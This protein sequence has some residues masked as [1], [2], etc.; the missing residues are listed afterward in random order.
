MTRIVKLAPALAAALVASQAVAAEKPVTAKVCTNCHQPQEGTLRG[1]FDNVAFKSRSIQIKFDDAVEVV[2]FD[3]KAIEVKA[4]AKTDPAEALREVKKG[5]EIKIAFVVKDG[6]KEATAVYLK[7]PIGVPEEMIIKTAEVRALVDQGPEAGKYTLVDSRPAPKYAEGYVP[8][9]VNLPFPAFDKLTDRLPADKAQLL[10]FYCGGPTCSMSPKSAE[11]AKALGYTNVKVYH[12]GFPGWSKVAAG[13]LTPKFLKE[14]WFDKEMP[15]VLL[16]ARPAAD[17]ETGFIQGAV[18]VPAGAPDAAVKALKLPAAEK[19]APVVVYDSGTGDLAAKLAA[20]A[21]ASGQTNVRVLEGGF[22][23]WEKAGLAAAQGKLAQAVAW[24]P[25]PKP[26]E[27]P[28]PEFQAL[29]KKVPAD[30]LILDVRNADEVAQ[31]AVKGAKNIPADEIEKRAAELPQDKR[32]V[33]HCSTGV[34]AEMA[35][36]LLKDRGFTKVAF[37][38]APIAV[39]RKGKV[40]LAKQ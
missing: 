12:E 21:V 28:F 15:V 20:A 40:T 17:A 19:K 33:T 37:V 8:T 16:D 1:Y 13:G 2:R 11:K 14:T 4:G 32:I 23:A 34:R 10:V 38:N 27:L 29:A 5:H 36:N 30:T 3:P 31:G 24:A 25:K 7:Q 9:A 6:V 26:G 39:D 18:A 35:Y 22:A